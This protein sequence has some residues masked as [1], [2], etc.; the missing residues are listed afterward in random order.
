MVHYVNFW[1]NNEYFRVIFF[2]M[3]FL[4]LELNLFIFFFFH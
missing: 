2:Y 3:A 4:K 1:F